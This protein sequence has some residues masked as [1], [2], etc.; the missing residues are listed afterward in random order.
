LFIHGLAPWTEAPNG[1]HVYDIIL[2]FLFLNGFKPSI[3][4]V[5][6]MGGWSIAVETTFYAFAPI[7]HKYINNIFKAFYLLVIASPL[8][9]FTSVYL[10]DHVSKEYHQYICFLSFP[11]EF[12][13]FCIGLLTYFIWNKYILHHSINDNVASFKKEI[14]LV[15]LLFSFA[16]AAAN[17]PFSY[18]NLYLTSFSFLP[19]ILAVSLYEWRLLVNSVTIFIGKIS[20]SMYLMSGIIF[21]GVEYFQRN[22]TPGF[23]AR[24][25]GAHYYFIIMF[26]VLTILD[27][28]LSTITHYTIEKPGMNLGKKLIRHIEASGSLSAALRFKRNTKKE[29]T[30]M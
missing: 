17:F 27:I 20:Y 15:L 1:I 13:V 7:L 24:Q 3:I 14:S 2:G 11:V 5:I 12:P 29:T 22:I 9:F 30:I 28:G 10:N 23:S 21:S 18:Q 6:A 25:S 8:F 4:N 26:L 19:F 16:F